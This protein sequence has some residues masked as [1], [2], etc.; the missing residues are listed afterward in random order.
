VTLELADHL[1]GRHIELQLLDDALSE[2]AAGDSRAIE[3][4]GAAGIGKT[5]LLAELAARADA[6]GY[7]VLTGSGA[8]L[9]Q[10]LPFW[11]F[12]DALDEYVESVEPR[13]LDNLDDDVRA[14]LAQVFPALSGL[15]RGGAVGLQD[16]RY[17]VNRAVRELLERL[18]ATKP[19]VLIL[20]DLHWADPASVDLLLSLVHRPPSASVLTVVA[21]RPHKGAARLTTGLQR[22][23]RAGEVST[24]P[25]DALTTEEAAALLS[26]APSDEYVAAL[27]EE[28]GGNPFY[29]EQLVRAP[30]AKAASRSPIVGSAFSSELE[31]PPMVVASMAEELSLISKRARLLLEGA[32]IAGDPFEPEL[33]AA[34]ADVTEPEAIDAIDELLASDLVRST[35]VPRRFRFRHPIVRRAVYEASPAGWRIG[36]HQRA[37]QAL[38]DR[39]ADARTLAHHVDISARVGDRAAIATLVEAG[40]GSAKRAPAAAAR[41]YSGA[42]RLLPDNASLEERTDLL[43]AN[44][45][46][47]AAIGRFEEAR[48]ALVESLALV[49]DPAAAQRLMIV[50]W[51]ARV[52]RLLGRSQEAHDRLIAALAD[53][54]DASGPQAIVLMLELATDGV[55]HLDY[56]A[57]QE[58]A[59]RA[60]AAARGIGDQALTAA[61]LAVLTRALAWGSSPDR[62]DEVRA[63]LVTIVDAL[64]DDEL[65]ERLDAMV[66]LASAEIYLDR[67]ADAAE[68]AERALA[69]GRATGQGHLFP[70][71]YATLGVAWCLS[72]RLPEAA[73][74]L[75]TAIEAARLSGNP[76]SLAWALFCRG[77]VA[78]PAGENRTAVATAQESLDLA[79]QSGQDVIAARA[80]S[81]LGV[82]LLEAGEPARATDALRRSAGENFAAIPHVWRAYLL[83]LMTRCWLSLGRPKEAREA[84]AA[85]A[86]SA[87]AA[88]LRSARATGLR[89]T[90]AVA[91]EA[92]DVAVAVKQALDAVELSK[93]VVTPVEAGLAQTIAGRALGR[94]GEQERAIALI[95][96]AVAEF[97][98]CGAMRYRDAA[99]RELRQLGKRIHRR[100]RP[101]DPNETGVAS[102]TEREL[103]IARLIV[104]RRTNGEIA[105]ELFLSKKTIETHVRNLFRKLDASSRVEVARRVEETDRDR[106]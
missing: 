83:E 21:R 38:V 88:G 39:A 61:A 99:E 73:E 101:G 49:A 53:L 54:S 41:W 40:R 56:R 94:H 104:D 27:Y 43:L 8:E 11:V 63:E 14:E 105:S 87:A 52:E 96:A 103:E 1:V 46:A 84:A 29:L 3:V 80:A 85:A 19:L 76:A 26:G 50:A 72:G 57:G 10:D 100:S 16:E 30:G 78:L 47:L 15:G 12:V 9:E 70:G 48:Q 5:R 45:T 69:I 67:F 81:V 71:I 97:E 4:V 89:A 77:F 64:G 7:I 79:E 59:E 31:V 55:L 20:D 25:L 106:G 51:C 33:A 13:R 93:A 23:V 102:L 28:S 34:A 35:S 62:A 60:V 86:A 36:A 95:E 2:V 17:R 22:A 32:S 58:W 42:L 68:H 92:G 82:A 44:A 75:D 66:D 18:A 74:L 24:I 90:A 6:R 98:S 37:A 65:A 91:L